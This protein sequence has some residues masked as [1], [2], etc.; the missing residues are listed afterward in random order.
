MS[1]FTRRSLL[2]GAGSAA[3][4]INGR[5]AV[6]A[7]GAGDWPTKPIRFVVNFGT[8]GATDSAA[9][10]YAERLTRVLGQPVVVENKG[11]ASGAIGAEAVVKSAPDGYTFLV[12]PGLPMVTLPHLRKLSFDPLKDLTPVASIVEG[13]VL[14]ATNT[15]IPGNNLQEFVAYAKANPGKLAWGTTGVGTYSHFVYETFKH[16]AGVDILHVPYRSAGESMADLLANVVQMVSDPAMMQHVLAGKAKLHAI[17]A[18]TRR[19]DFPN[20]P[21]LKEVYPEI[22]FSAWFGILAPAG[23]PTPILERLSAACNEV[24]AMTDVN[25]LLFGLALAPTPSNPASTRRLLESDY[26]R[27]GRLIKQFDIRAE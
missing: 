5:D 24:G 17:L 18:S 4:L 26:A 10:A 13:L 3:L 21:M 14:L 12:T 25:A 27:F 23:T 2:K 15:T 6:C 19:P 16:Y 7:Q 1:R 20:V 11:G 9:R 8:A 22:D